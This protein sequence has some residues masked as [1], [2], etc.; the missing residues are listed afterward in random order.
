M[1]AK[2]TGDLIAHY[3]V[4]MTSTALRYGILSLLCH[5]GIAPIATQLN[6]FFPQPDEIE[7]DFAGISSSPPPSHTLSLLHTRALPCLQRPRS[8]TTTSAEWD[9]GLLNARLIEMIRGAGQMI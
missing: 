8:F 7:L 9:P 4:P 3:T 5:V 6:C 1:L 2:T